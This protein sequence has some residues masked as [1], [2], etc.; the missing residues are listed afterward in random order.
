MKILQINTCCGIGSTGRIAVE[1]SNKCAEVGIQ[2]YIAYGVKH[3]NYE[4]SFKIGSNISYYFHNFLSRFF[5]NEGGYSYFATKRFLKWVDEINPDIIHLHNIHGHY[6]NIKMVFKYI[7]MKNISCV[8]TLHDCWAFTGHCTY[9]D[10]IGCKKWKTQCFLCPQIKKYPKSWILDRS[11]RNFLIKRKL[12]TSPSNMI[13]VTPSNWLG[14]LAKQSFLGKYPVEVIHNGIDLNTFKPKQSKFRE[15]HNL[16][17]KF[18]VLGVAFG[19]GERKGFKYFLELA[20][21]LGKTFQVVMVGVTEE[22]KQSLP[23]N[24]VSI[25]KT[26][27][28]EEL[29][30]IYSAADIFINPT[31]E[32]NFPTTNLE[33]LACGTPVITFNTG[34]SIESIDEGCGIVVAKENL[35]ELYNAI[36]KVKESNFTTNSC[37][38][39]AKLFDKNEKNNEYVFMYKSLYEK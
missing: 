2:N 31:L 6:I 25:L 11:K 28:V 9:F 20:N 23:K 34:G 39:R 10:Y 32:D 29:A 35:L 26:N 30:G 4:K 17:N 5:C 37:L 12:F 18:I 38:E 1:I 27:S 21:R 15:K 3:T 33:S 16:Q 14:D 8:W 22:Q 24:I 13:I 19:F 36:I 7:T